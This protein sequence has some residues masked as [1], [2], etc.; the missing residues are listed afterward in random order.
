MVAI[1]VALMFVGLILID[2]GIEKWRVWR[3]AHPSTSTSP[4]AVV[5]DYGF[6][7]LF[8][9][10]DGIH[11]SSQHTWV[12]ADPIGG[13]Q[14]GVDALIA[15]AV[16]AVGRIVLPKVGDVVTVGEPL[17]RLENNGRAVNISSTLTGRVTAVNY[18]LAEKPELLTSDPYGRGWVCH[19]TP[20]RAEQSAR[21]V[22]FGEQA[23]K[24]LEAEFVRFRE[25]I[26]AQASPDF[27]VGVTSQDGGLPSFGCLG[28]L[29]PSA[30]SAFEANFLRQ[31]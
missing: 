20:T 7:A 16:G 17:A 27:A 11:L 26:S 1:F 10:P 23:A 30:W 25:F 22:R 4:R 21:G 14:I 24:W 6:D 28:E 12:K 2:L 31:P 29:G 5:G 19:L 15:R 3:V 8:Q 13:L 18:R 9:V